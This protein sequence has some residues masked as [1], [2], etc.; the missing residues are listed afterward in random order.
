MSNKTQNQVKKRLG[1]NLYFKIGTFY[2]FEAPSLFT[3][4]AVLASRSAPL[5]NLKLKV[6]S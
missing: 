3:V 2:D 6:G 4:R 5:L 1:D